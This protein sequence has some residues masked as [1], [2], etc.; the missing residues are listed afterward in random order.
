MDDQ[1]V[2]TPASAP[3]RRGTAAVLLY[4][5]FF[6][7]WLFRDADR[8]SELERSAAV[9]HN[10]AQ[11]RWLP[12]YMLRWAVA[13]GGLLALQFFADRVLHSGWLTAVFAVLVIYD[14]MFQLITGICWAFLHLDRQQG[15]RFWRRGRRPA[16]R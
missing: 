9:R 1:P 12:L 2:H 16:G 14:I 4:R 15:Q 6:Y 10:T 3:A 11:A 5:Y 8:G 13:G 7:G